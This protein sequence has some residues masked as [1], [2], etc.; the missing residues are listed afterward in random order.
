MPEVEHFVVVAACISHMINQCLL[1]DVAKHFVS[2]RSLFIFTVINNSVSV[3]LWMFHLVPV[4]PTV[5]QKL[6]GE[7][8]M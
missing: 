2:L 5:W 1:R 8:L 7:V 6:P 4:L 3:K